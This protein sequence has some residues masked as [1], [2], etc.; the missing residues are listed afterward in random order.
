MSASHA[1]HTQ[2]SQLGLL[3]DDVIQRTLKN[4]RLV[5]TVVKVAVDGDDVY[6]RAA[7][8]ADRE[9]SKPMT[10][11][12]LFRLA[13]VSKPIISVAALVLVAQ[14]RIGLDDD[15]HQWL[16]EFRPHL[17]SGEPAKITLR[18]LLTQ[19]FA[20]GGSGMIG[21]AGDFLHIWSLLV[22]RPGAQAQCR[23]FYQYGV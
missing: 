12:A 18:Q 20:S 17:R 2:N 14:G 1:F 19:A 7:G 11:D 21:T 15:I 22:R 8:L 6:S 16:P 10:E 9:T 3:I 5:G 4:H 23:R 13:S